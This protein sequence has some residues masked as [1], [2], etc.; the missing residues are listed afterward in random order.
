MTRA[1]YETVY[2]KCIASSVPAGRGGARFS[3]GARFKNPAYKAMLTK[4]AACMRENGVNVPAP[5]T[6]GKGPIFDTKGI[7]TA[8]TQFKTAETKCSGDLRNA[9]HRAHPGGVV[10]GAAPPG[11]APAG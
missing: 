8:S 5:D 4:F 1:Q 7:N 2:R 11:A 10:P 6:A 9:F 3:G